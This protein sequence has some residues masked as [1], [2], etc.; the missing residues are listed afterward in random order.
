M[1][2]MRIKVPAAV[3]VIPL[4][5]FMLAGCL[6]VKSLQPYYTEAAA[7]P[8]PDWLLGTWVTTDGGPAASFTKASIVFFD[9]GAEFR[10]DAVYFIAG[11]ALFVDVTFSD[12][13]WES[14]GEEPGGL[15]MT[16][17]T[18]PVHLLLRPERISDQEAIIWVLSDESDEWMSKNAALTSPEQWMDMLDTGAIDA[19]RFEDIFP[20]IKVST[21]AEDLLP[22]FLRHLDTDLFGGDLTQDGHRGVS[23]GVC[24]VI[25]ASSSECRG[26][27]YVLDKS[28]CWPKFDVSEPLP[29]RPGLMSAVKLE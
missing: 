21:Q 10:F 13:Q 27:S 11:G 26:Y 24:E 18:Q 25:C 1:K 9:Y 19:D 4:A 20:A 23:L 22:E 17:A 16:A 8:A 15:T 6:P 14:I 5:G 12:E 3:L 2:A 7:V 28:W 29:G